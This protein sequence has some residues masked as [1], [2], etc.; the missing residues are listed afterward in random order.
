MPAAAAMTLARS[1]SMASAEASTARMRIRDLQIF[2]NALYGAVFA[3]RPVQCVE[4][5]I[6]VEPLQHLGDVAADIHAGDPVAFGLQGIGTGRCPK[7][8]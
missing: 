6:G 8:G 1:L 4:C 5:D 2:Q 7:T 3:E